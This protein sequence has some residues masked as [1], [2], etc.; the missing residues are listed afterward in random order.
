M[1]STLLLGIL[2]SVILFLP[3]FIDMSGILGTGS[4]TESGQTSD[5]QETSG[6]KQD[7]K[8]SQEMIIYDENGVLTDMSVVNAI[9]P[10]VNFTM[11]SSVDEVR[12]MVENETAKAGFVVKSPTEFDYYVFNQGMSSTIPN[13]FESVL[14]TIN[15]I[16]YCT[17]N[18][19]DYTELEDVYNAPVTVNEQI[20]GKDTRSNYWYCY[21][22]V[23]LVFMMIIFYGVMIATSVTTE[24]SNRSIEVL[25]TSTN[26]TS[27]LFG[28]VIAGAVASLFQAFVVLGLVL[29]SYQINRDAWGGMLDMVLNIPSDVLITFGFFGLG[30]F[31]FYA[32]LYGAM[33]ALVSKTEDINKSAGS[34]Q[35]IIMI[36][37][38]IVLF[39]L[40]NPD[41]ILMKVCSFLPVSSYSAMFARVAMGTVAPWEVIV[42]FV[43]LVISIIGVGILG[44]KIYRMG[45][46][47]YGNPI[48]LTNALKGLKKND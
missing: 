26:P 34:V 43:I 8:P 42:S 9:F 14:T 19:L 18:G 28:K 30:G 32:F 3:S 46:L 29:V 1:I 5:K 40:S 48:K 36:V 27:L 33:G 11:A 12:S 31:L 6:D 4:K 45:T 47:R 25:V 22:L 41:G 24:K 38:F 10:D 7:N 35:M 44:A 17:A 21:A 13:M 37:Y 15:R 16:N 2:L 20:L 39:Q 23:I